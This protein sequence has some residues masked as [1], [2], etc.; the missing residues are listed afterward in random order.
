MTTVTDKTIIQ[1]MFELY[2]KCMCE[3][4]VLWL[5][6]TVSNMYN[7]E[8]IVFLNTTDEYGIPPLSISYI[9]QSGQ[10]EYIT[11]RNIL[12]YNIKFILK[13]HIEELNNNFENEYKLVI[14]IQK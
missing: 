14:Y 8:Y 11:Y 1:R 2:I 3:E 12:N 10:H 4:L 5:E 6:N 7:N 9:V 13:L